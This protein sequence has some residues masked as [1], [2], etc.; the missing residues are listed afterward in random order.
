M[1]LN[2]LFGVTGKVALV[3]G[4]GTGI[5][6]MV[7]EALAMGG[8]RVMICSR[9]LHVVEAAADQ[10]N[11]Q[12]YRG[13]IEAFAGDVG[14]EQGIDGIAQEVRN[15]T[16]AL[17]ILVNNAGVTWGAE[18]GEFPY[19]AWR[20]VMS[21]NVDGLFHLT[22]TLLPE[23][24]ASASHDDP[25]RVINLGSVMGAV[26]M[27]DGAYSYA[28]SKAAVH[29]I[30]RILAK[31]LAHEHITVNAFAPGPFR[32]RMTAFATADD[33]AARKVGADVPL[34]R[35]GAPEDIAGATLFLC[36]KG[37]AYVTGA[38][39]PLCGGIHVQT[40]HNIFRAALEQG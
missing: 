39:L 8:A 5:G 28:A 30:T 4:G 18:L 13:R 9:K 24:R 37:G 7:A 14:S 40:S 10:I 38:I 21:V 35:V 25:A 22:Q 36:G 23:L 26:P 15:R 11:A 27:G 2:S 6:R 31:E 20:K 3:T 16:R 29:Q 34:G 19:A 1:D 17:D 32:S 33:E 12:G